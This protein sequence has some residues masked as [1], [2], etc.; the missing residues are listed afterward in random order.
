MSKIQLKEEVVKFSKLAEQKGLVN[1]YEGNLSII[2]REEGLLYITPSG[3]RKLWL[4]EGMIAVYRTEDMVQIEGLP[5]SSEVK[6]HKAAYDAR[7]D[8]NG[9]FHCHA[10][11][12]TAFAYL[13]QDIKLDCSTTFIEA[14]EVPCLPYGRPGTHDIHKGIDEALENHKM[15]LCGNHGCLAVEEDLEHAF[16][17]L[18]MVE[19]AVHIYSIAKQFGEP[20]R[21]TDYEDLY[22]MMEQAVKHIQL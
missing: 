3:K 16:N 11:Y 10:P 4:N 7:P 20:K 22:Q 12:L 8:L 9:A 17:L 6:L 14:C 19:H 18:E 2:D 21:I 13:G 5:G 15:V 1:A